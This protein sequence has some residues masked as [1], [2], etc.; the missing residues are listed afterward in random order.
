MRIKITENQHI[1]LLIEAKIDDLFEKYCT[2][3]ESVG[4]GCDVIK[5][6]VN[7]LDPTPT[8][9]FLEWIIKNIVINDERSIMLPDWANHVHD[10]ILRF[11]DLINKNQIEN[12]DINSYNNFDS[13]VKVVLDAEDRVSKKSLSGQY[14]KLY[15]DDEYLMVRPLTTDASCKFGVDTKW[16]IAAKVDNRFSQYTE[17]K[18]NEFFFVIKKGAGR[19][20]HN[21]LALQITNYGRITV[22]NSE[23]R[24]EDTKILN[25]LPSGIVKIVNDRVKEIKN[26]DISCYERF[27]HI[28]SFY[29]GEEL[30]EFKQT[31]FNVNK[32]IFALYKQELSDDADGFYFIAIAKSYG[33]DNIKKITF[34]LGFNFNGKKY[35][36]SNYTEYCTVDSA[37]SAV[38]FVRNVNE[39]FLTIKR[40]VAKIK[41]EFI[42]KG[43]F[44]YWYP[45]NSAS[46]YSFENPKEAGK[47]TKAFISYVKEQNSI[48]KP[49]TQK[50]FVEGLGRKYYPGYLSQFFGSIKDSGIVVRNRKGEYQLGPNYEV[51]MQGKLRRYSTNLGR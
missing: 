22:W 35:F 31:K 11:N 51:Y 38:S 49:A 27:E 20:I 9:K 42:K 14:D 15:E 37:E 30:G 4:Y 43:D 45:E 2:R 50:G 7:N 6:L 16:C 1:F 19:G 29:F 40:R 10:Y 33:V 13:L 24:V 47:T 39:R 32:D 5:K 26:E 46:T 28:D 12:K 8:K 17:K 21:R 34:T 3:I 48:G 18:Q 44:V 23:D 41:G 36:L 25:T